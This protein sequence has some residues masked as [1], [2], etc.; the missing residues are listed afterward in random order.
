[1]ATKTKTI[2]NIK[3][4][5]DKQR[6]F[7]DSNSTRDIDFRI[8]QLKKFKK[9]IQD[10]E[11]NIY[12]AL[13]ADFKKSKFESFATEIGVLYEEISCM[14]KN[15]KKWA[16]PELVKDTIANFPSKNYIYQDPYGVTLIIGAWNYP[17]QLTLAPVIG[18]IAA[19]NTCIIKPPRAAINTYHV[20][21]KI[22]SDTF[23][24]NYLAVLDEH[25]DNN[26]MLSYRYDYIFFTGGVEIGKTIARAAAEFLTPTT[27]ELGGKSPCIVDKQVDIETAARRIAWG[28]FLNGGQTCVA[29]DYLLLHDAVKEKFYKAFA[30]SV[31]EFYGNNPQDSADYPR[32]INDRHFNRLAALIKDGEIIVGGQTDADT[33][34]IAPTLIEIDSL[35]HPLMSDEIFGPIL[36]VLTIQSID[37]AIS[38]VKQF[39]K[40]LAFYIFSNN[41]SNQQKCL[42]TVQFGGGC[43]NDTVSHFINDGLP[44]GGVGNSGVGA[45]HGKFS[46][47]TFTHKKG[48]CHKVTWPDVPLRYPPYNGKLMLVKQVM[49]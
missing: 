33:R 41:Y 27:L 1:M 13:N 16:T 34:Y 44:F 43:V 30:K 48:V 18:A 6:D 42:N 28:K 35:D 26:E 20:I 9:A 38:I 12:A 47:D 36:P 32:I 37:E 49:K 31:K 17:L 15:V 3:L 39:E 21:E 22:I 46:F 8:E 14:L 25:S 5:I 45:Y 40:P 19:G 23:N 10:N 4:V 29:P 11:E 7:F 2:S 24:E